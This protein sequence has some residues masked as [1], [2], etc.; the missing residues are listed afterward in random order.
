M[1]VLFPLLLSDSPPEPEKKGEKEAA[2]KKA[3][4]PDSLAR[5]AAETA[6]T[7][8]TQLAVE[9]GTDTD[10]DRDTDSD[11]SLDTDTLSDFDKDVRALL[12]EFG[13]HSTGDK[14][15]DYFLVAEKLAR[16]L[17]D[18]LR[19]EG[20]GV[21][22]WQVCLAQTCLETGYGY[23]MSQKGRDAYITFGIKADKAYKGSS[24]SSGT[25]DGADGH[26]NVAAFRSYSSIRESFHA[27][28]E[29]LNN[30][31]RYKPAF[32]HSDNP[33]LFLCALR[34]AKYFED[35][36]YIE[37]VEK[38]GKQYGFEFPR[39]TV[40]PSE[41]P[42]PKPEEEG[43]LAKIGQFFSKMGA[44]ASDTFK[45]TYASIK[46][47]ILGGLTWL[48]FDVG[49]VE[50]KVRA[51]AEEWK[52]KV[53]DAAAPVFT[54]FSDRTPYI[55]SDFGGRVDPMDHS[56]HQNHKGVDIGR[57]PDAT[58]LVAT[59]DVKVVNVGRS[60]GGGNSI[61]VELVPSDGKTYVFHHLNDAI[62]KN[63][64]AK[65]TVIH[66]GET[67]ALSGGTGKRVTGPHVHFE[68]HAGGQVVDPEPYLGSKLA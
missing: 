42:G 32:E 17:E 12:A 66:P 1:S 60:E 63:P 2:E 25:K 23:G 4:L 39:G 62:Q 6:P 16:E 35:P 65:G 15:H 7:A 41:G 27:Y 49:K 26:D 59:H 30:Q 43:L 55:S 58:P 47:S 13:L 40:S 5:L 24:V 44:A 64:P 56:K 46:A 33:Y 20:K 36:R 52:N 9:L 8:R 22:P 18:K 50:E 21:V 67:I 28:G 38:I 10:A 61:T 11:G 51:G 45:K 48:G 53:L 54:F 3:P 37:K 68:V 57:V 14:K 29:F 19:R 31:P 34:D